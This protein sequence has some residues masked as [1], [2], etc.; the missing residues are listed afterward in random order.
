M[1]REELWRKLVLVAEHST[2]YQQAL[3]QL[4][5]IEADYSA[6][7]ETLAPEKQEVLE[8]YI[9]ACEA[10]DESLVYLAYQLGR[11]D[12]GYNGK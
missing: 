7:L 9:A 10:M 2:D 5:E 1:D 4:K 3:Q 8:R 12:S 6:L 11:T